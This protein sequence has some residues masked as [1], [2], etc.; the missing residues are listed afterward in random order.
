M[1]ESNR[2]L[3][4]WEM[5]RT[6]MTAL[7]PGVTDN[8]LP[9]RLHPQSNTVGWLLRHI[10]EVE[11]LFAKNVFGLP[12]RVS[13]YTLK[14]GQSRETY[15]TTSEL[16]DHLDESAARLREA[17]AGQGPDSWSDTVTTA[18][19]GTVSKREALAR[20][21]THTAYHAGQLALAL[22]YGAP[23]PEVR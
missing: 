21:I 10:G 19:F 7:L 16:L 4:M 5:G 12:V 22:K 15:G 2:I 11:Q 3:A 1:D 14:G 23:S 18:E 17:I 13:A 9:N 20:V 6:R 8:I